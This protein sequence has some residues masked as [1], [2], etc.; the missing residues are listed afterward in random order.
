MLPKMIFVNPFH[1]ASKTLHTQRVNLDEERPG[2]D[3]YHSAGRRVRFRN[4]HRLT[5]MAEH[6]HRVVC[7]RSCI[8]GIRASAVPRFAPG[9]TC[10]SSAHKDYVLYG[11]EIRS[12]QGKVGWLRGCTRLLVCSSSGCPGWSLMQ[13]TDGL[14]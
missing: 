5:A 12:G 11:R 7:I 3:A 13:I 6:T 4:G 14:R 8:I 2:T 9:I 10:S 1:A